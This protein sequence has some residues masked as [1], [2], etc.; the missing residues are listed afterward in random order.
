MRDRLLER[1]RSEILRVASSHGARN[2]RVFGSRARGEGDEQSDVDILVE[3]ERGRTLLDL[4]R[5]K[6]DLEELTHRDVDVV[7]DDGLSPI[8]RDTILSQAVAL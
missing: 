6:R 2:V 4:V 1:H 7:T 8:L 3:L 5:L